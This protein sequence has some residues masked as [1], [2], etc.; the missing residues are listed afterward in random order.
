M[1]EMREGQAFQG[2]QWR[3]ERGKRATTFGEEGGVF[4]A[5]PKKRAVAGKLGADYPAKNPPPSREPR[6]VKQKR[7]FEK[8]L[9]G[10][11]IR[12]MAKPDYPVF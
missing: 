3:R 2:Q 11:I 1:E 9:Q 4:I 12:P 7:R 10:R 6:R 8:F 5:P